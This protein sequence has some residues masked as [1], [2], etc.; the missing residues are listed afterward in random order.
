V[1]QAPCDV[2]FRLLVQGV[3][4]A[5]SAVLLDFETIFELLLILEAVIVYAIAACALQFDEIVLGHTK[6]IEYS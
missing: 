4:A 5:P 6:L 3:F 2:L 1:R